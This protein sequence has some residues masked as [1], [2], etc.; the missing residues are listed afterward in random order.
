MVNGVKLFNYFAEIL[1]GTNFFIAN[2]G[3]YIIR[4]FLN[5][6]NFYLILQVLGFN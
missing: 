3:E 1:I 2:F 4:Y 6:S 5:Y